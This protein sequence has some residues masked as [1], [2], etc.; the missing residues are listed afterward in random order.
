MI[1]LF[2][3]FKQKLFFAC[4]LITLLLACN[5][6]ALSQTTTGVSISWNA[7][8]GCQVFSEHELNGHKD[9]V[10]LEDIE[11]GTCIRVCENTPVT[12]TLSGSLGSSPGT[13]WSVTGGTIYNQTTSTCSVSWGFAGM[14]ELSFTLTTPT[15]VVT[16]T[17]CI[18]KII[19]P[20]AL[21]NVF[22]EDKPFPEP[23]LACVNQT[24]YFTNLSSANEGTAIVPPSFWDFGDGTYSTEFE[25]NHMYAAP[26][27]YDV[28]LTVVNSCNC[29]STYKRVIKVSEYKGFDIICPG[30]V[31]EG[32]SATYSLPEE[33]SESCKDSYDWSVIGGQILNVDSSNGDVTV[34]WN[35]VDASGFG[36]LTFD[37]TKCGLKCVQPSTL[38]IPV[39]QVV[40]TIQGDLNTCVGVQS[41]YK[42]PQWPTTVFSWSIDG[43]ENGDLAELVHTEQWN[44]VVVRPLVPGTLILRATYANTLLDCGGTAS[45]EITADKPVE[46]TGTEV[47][48]RYSTGTYSTI[49]GQNTNWTLTD[50]AGAIIYTAY[51]SNTFSWYFNTAGNYTLSVGSSAYCP[52]QSLSI[53][54]LALPTSPLASSIMVMNTNGTLVQASTLEVCPNAPYTYSIAGDPTVQ[55]RWEVAPTVG[56]IIGSAV[57]NQVSISFIGGIPAQI[58]V[59]KESISPL[60][61]SSSPTTIPI[62]YK[63]ISAAISAANTVVCANSNRNYQAVNPG[64][65]PE[66]LHTDGETYTWSIS[67]NTLG[68]ITSG[69]GT[70]AIGIL[71]NNTNIVATATLT[72]TIKKCTLT[73]VLT[74][75]VTVNPVPQIAIVPSVT[76]ICSG[77]AMTFDLVSTNGV[78]ITSGTVTWNFGYGPQSGSITGQSFTFSNLTTA[79]IGQNVTAVVSDAN[80]CG[81]TT[82]T[83]NSTVTVLP[84]PPATLSLSTAYNAFCTKPEI[85][86]VLVVAS[87]TSGVTFQ[88]F[89]DNVLISGLPT[90]TTTITITGT[91]GGFGAYHFVAT[92]AAGCSTASNPIYIVRECP[93]EPCEYS[94]TPS[95]TNTSTQNCGTINLVGTTTG[96]P[97]STYWTIIGPPNV[98]LINYTGTSYTATVAGDFHTFYM[99]DYLN[100]TTGIVCTF[101]KYKKVTIPYI[102]DFAY[103]AA[104]NGNNNFTITFTD[105]T[106]FYSPVDNR[107]VTYFY[108]PVTMPV[109]AWLPVTGTSIPTLNAGSYEFKVIV[110]GDYAGTTQPICE[111]VINV[112]LSTIPDQEINAIGVLCHDSA[113]EFSLT[114]FAQPGDSY[115]W[116]FEP[117]VVGSEATNTLPN[118]KRVFPTSGIKTV[119]VVITNRFGCS[120]EFTITNVVIPEKCFNGTVAATPNPPTVCAGAP[121]TLTYVPSGTECV[122][123][124]YIWMNGQSPVTP[125]QNLPTIQVSTSGFYWVIVKKGNCTYETPNRIT[126]LFKALPSIRLEVPSASCVGAPVVVK[127]ISNATFLRWTVNGAPQPGFNNLTS[128][129]LYGLTAGTHTIAV[130]AYSGNPTAPDTCS[131]VASQNIVVVNPPN[132][133]VITQQIFCAGANPLIPYYHVILTATSNVSSVFNWSNGMTGSTIT[134]VDGGPYQVRVTNGGCS[135]TAQIDVPRNPEDYIWVFPAGCISTCVDINGHP[136]LIGPRLPLT[137]WAWLING[138]NVMSDHDS[139]TEPIDIALTNEI[140]LEINTGACGIVSPTLNYTANDHCTKCPTNN[141]TV[142]E[143]TPIEGPFCSFEVKLTIT[144]MGDFTGILSA[145]NDDFVVVPS[146]LN[147]VT[148]L[149][150]VVVTIIPLDNFTGGNVLFQIEG[151]LKDGTPCITQFEINVP[152]CPG[153]E[154]GSS[155]TNLE[156]EIGAKKATV[157]M[158]PN[159][160]DAEVVLTYD[161]LLV[162]STIA[163]YDLT[164]RLLTDFTVTTTQGSLVI[165][166]AIY[167]SGTYI[168]VVRSNGFIVAQQKLIVK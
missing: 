84:G 159:P 99:A 100:T 77:S 3:L 66:T 10:T 75:T 26:G 150:S 107:S 16:K 134:V 91:F 81:E 54:V 20:V 17:I 29:S 88:W 6:S 148:G 9:P 163:L 49:Y 162:N 44:E 106:N 151:T 2:T 83:A 120:R 141:I 144:S 22:P 158:A 33:I 130:T 27:T 166:T 65:S 132:T 31:C 136:T 111:K 128:V 69:Q 25:P 117:G 161:S 72:L 123:T 53:N 60:I 18:E 94:P 93:D 47:L 71:W 167:P 14:G 58:K 98:N 13:V 73:R 38:K 28:V 96:T 24:L 63:K 113:V 50:N 74:K 95:M 109:G 52:A 145:P 156:K 149:N 102:P 146:Q 143:V 42:L 108:R 122:P 46:I 15:G 85:N 43:N 101:N 1:K 160:A 155:K 105:K 56:T 119:K 8:V 4:T 112:T 139:Y 114:E 5:Y 80:G 34:L 55:Y 147:I 7:E 76:S 127:A 165:P 154:E 23:I 129:T 103:T 67:P 82:N 90:S 61:C 118:P 152:S 116:T 48:C 137:Y 78:P 32:A 89:K 110:Q 92:N 35:D 19:K 51:N 70:N 133:P 153:L 41:I 157:V 37:P 97:Q 57:G 11:D 62:Y 115:L 59:Y 131:A 36:Y 79:N 126:P 135:A 21:F 68:S 124:Q 164:G 39:I 140:N 45:F 168:V 86:A 125:P 138:S 121:V 87:A 12:Y 64:V 30:V 142:D 40:G 104:C